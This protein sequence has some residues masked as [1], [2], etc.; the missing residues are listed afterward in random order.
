MPIYLDTNVFYSAYCPIDD[1][2]VADWLLNQTSSKF[3]AI[4]SEWTIAEMFRGLKKQVNLDR[5]EEADAQVALNLFL[6]DIWKYV[7]EKRLFLI[8]VKI[9]F[10]MAA[11]PFIFDRNLYAADAIHA[12]TA[13]QT[14]AEAFITFDSDFKKFK[15]IPVLYPKEAKFK[16]KFNQLKVKHQD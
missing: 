6:S 12:V 10:I 3:P 4:T 16:D 5:I 14:N 1:R 2:F 15:E 7:H 13:I 8:P 9:S 11:R